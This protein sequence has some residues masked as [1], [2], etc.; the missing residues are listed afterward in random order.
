MFETM[1][2]GHI[3]ANL[4]HIFNDCFAHILMQGNTETVSKYL[5]LLSLLCIQHYE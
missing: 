5:T 4:E 1:K 3:L 2:K